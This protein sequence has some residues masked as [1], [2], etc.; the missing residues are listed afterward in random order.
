MAR[1]SEHPAP[2]E[3]QNIQCARLRISYDGDGQGAGQICV[4]HLGS[5]GAVLSEGIFTPDEA[6]EYAQAILKAYDAVSGVE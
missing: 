5:S 6:Y 4:K 2:T 1:P 3:N